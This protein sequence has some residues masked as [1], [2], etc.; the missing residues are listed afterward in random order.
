M[1]YSCIWTYTYIKKKFKKKRI[2]KYVYTFVHNLYT[3]RYMRVWYVSHP[4]IHSGII[5]QGTLHTHLRQILRR[6]V[7]NDILLFILF[8]VH[9]TVYATCTCMLRVYVNVLCYIFFF[10][11]S[12]SFLSRFCFYYFLQTG[13]CLRFVG[14]PLNG[15]FELNNK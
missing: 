13:R 1:I 5:I 14:P 12:F 9:C 3:R 10:L 15:V 2:L 8:I 11:V 7:F 4:Q 6:Y